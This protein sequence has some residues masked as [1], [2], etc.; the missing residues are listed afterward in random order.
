MTAGRYERRRQHFASRLLGLQDPV[1]RHHSTCVFVRV[2]VCD[3]MSEGWVEQAWLVGG[4]GGTS[5]A[6]IIKKKKIQ[7][8]WSA[9]A[10][11]I[12]LCH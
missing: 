8:F 12:L 9:A 7:K 1:N 4:G 10:E 3:S 2:C 6:G 5:C 11:E